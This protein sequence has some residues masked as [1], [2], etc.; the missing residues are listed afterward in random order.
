MGDLVFIFCSDDFLLNM[1]KEYLEHDYFT[2]IITFDYSE[3]DKVAGEMYISIDRIM[4]NAKSMEIRLLDEVHRVIIHGV[5]H[6]CG[7]K[8]KSKKEEVAMRQAED[9]ALEMRPLLMVNL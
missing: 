6:L 2:D 4:D 7:Y 5:L 3:N 9:K 8:D 1:N